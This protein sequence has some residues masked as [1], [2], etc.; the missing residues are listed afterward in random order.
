MAEKRSGESSGCLRRV[1][2][3]AGRARAVDSGIAATQAYVTA[4]SFL[5]SFDTA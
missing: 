2:R 4:L 1:R 5:R 3:P